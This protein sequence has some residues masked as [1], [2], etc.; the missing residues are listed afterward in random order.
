M[1]FF[2]FFLMIRRPPR[3]T[4]SSSS[5][6]S[7]VYKRQELMCG[8]GGSRLSPF[9][10]AF[11]EDT[12]W[13]DADY[14]LAQNMTV[15][16]D[17][18]CDFV[19]EKCNVAAGGRGTAWHFD[20]AYGC[21]SDFRLI[22][23]GTWAAASPAPPAHEIYD[24]S[25]PT[26]GDA[27]NLA[28][29]CPYPIRV[30]DR[31]C[32]YPHSTTTSDSDT[33]M[34]MF[35]G[36]GG[37][38]FRG[39]GVKKSD[40]T[41]VF[42]SRC[43]KSRCPFGGK[44]IELAV[45]SNWVACPLDGS[46]KTDLA[47][48]APYEGNIECPL[49]TI[50]CADDITSGSSTKPEKPLT[51]SA[52]VEN[53]G[54]TLVAGSIVLNGTK[55]LDAVADTSQKIDIVNSLRIDLAFFLGID[56]K[57]IRTKRTTVSNT[58]IEIVIQI[59]NDNDNH[60]T[61]SA[62]SDR[63]KQFSTVSPNPLALTVEAY[64]QYGSASET[65]T[66]RS[67]YIVEPETGSICSS[68][69][70]EEKCLMMIG[71]IVIVGSTLIIWILMYCVCCRN[72]FDTPPIAPTGGKS[73]FTDIKGSSTNTNGGGKYDYSQRDGGGKDVPA[74]WKQSRKNRSREPV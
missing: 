2:F 21:S 48:P 64:A 71:I 56:Y 55:W 53:S 72:P 16:R 18:G 27:S 8:L 3:S 22:G 62:V 26:F 65:I 28:D 69:M 35:Y 47:A 23:K 54:G 57:S 20:T 51:S 37:R 13:Y 4:L 31:E 40:V 29:Y 49:A 34:G 68:T 15:G 17:Q 36:T 38:C 63:F 45:G 6:A 33:I 12:T 11:M 10:L 1:S 60:L 5:A 43:F 39:D 52:L 59:I 7:D 41:V 61:A 30:T 19:D 32:E 66:L 74:N 25:N 50:F 67:Y 14:S 9:S 46:A 70:T 24:T 44:R 73:N 42:T 58:N